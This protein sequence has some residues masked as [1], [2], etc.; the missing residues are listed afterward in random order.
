MPYPPPVPPPSRTNATPMV[1]NHPSD[2]LLTSGALSDIINELGANP[3]GTYPSVTA[4]LDDIH[5]TTTNVVRATTSASATGVWGNTNLI[6]TPFAPYPTVWLAIAMSTYTSDGGTY[7]TSTRFINQ[8]GVE[9]PWQQFR[10]GPTPLM[11][12]T[13]WAF[14]HTGGVLTIAT[15]ANSGLGPVGHGAGSTLLLV[16]LG[17]P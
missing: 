6:S 9:S 4:R 11:V 10:L 5:T 16:N 15:Q 3:S 8:S 7:D 17:P 1:D 13:L 2:H 14:S 12:T